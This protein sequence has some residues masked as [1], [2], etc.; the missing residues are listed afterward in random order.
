LKSKNAQLF[1]K[2]G[3]FLDAELGFPELVDWVQDKEEYW[4]SLPSSSLVRVLADTIM[5]TAYEVQAGHRDPE[6][7]TELVSAAML[8]ATP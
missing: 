5:L 7:L 6:E 2:T 3:R 4:A 1:V 8:P